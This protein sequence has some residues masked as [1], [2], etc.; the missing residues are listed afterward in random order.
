[1]ANAI[2]G[3]DQ[4]AV[5]VAAEESLVARS[6]FAWNNELGDTAINPGANYGFHFFTATV[7]PRPGTEVISN[8][9]IKRRT[10]GRPMPRLPEVE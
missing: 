5:M 7:V 9:S 6:W 10:P 3:G 8:S 4:D 1:M 2:N